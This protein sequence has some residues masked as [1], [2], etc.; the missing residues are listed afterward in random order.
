MKQ[1][2][3]GIDEGK[4][5]L[6]NKE[7]YSI[8]MAFFSYVA[9]G[10]F[11]GIAYYQVVMLLLF[12]LLFLLFRKTEYGNKK[13]RRDGLILSSLF[14][15]LLI[16]G[17]T[18]FIGF[19]NPKVS[20]IEG[21][22]QFQNIFVFIGFVFLFLCL[23]MHVLPFLVEVN[24]K[25]K[26]KMN[27][28]SIKKLFWIFLFVILLGWLPYLLSFY[29]GNLSSD[30][31]GEL[32]MIMDGFTHVSDHHPILHVLFMAIPYHVGNFIFHSKTAAVAC[33]SIVQMSMMASIFSYTAIFLYKR[34][35]EKKLIYA[36]VLFFALCPVFGYYSITM[37]KDVLFGGILLLLTI[38]MIVLFENKETLTIKKLLPFVFL[39]IITLFFRNN[40]IYMYFILA[41]V[42][43][44]IFKKEWK[45]FLLVFVLVIGFYYGV[46]GPVFKSL[47]I[48][49]SASAE[50]LAIPLQQM[51]RMAYKEGTFTEEDKKLL[52]PLISVEDL[53]K[54]YDPVIVDAIKFNKVYHGDVFDE[55]KG[56]Y[57]KLWAKLVVQNP[58]VAV[59]AYLTSTLGY[60]YPNIE[61][62]SVQKGVVDESYGVKNAAIEIPVLSKYVNDAEKRTLP[63]VSMQW[64]IGLGV[65]LLFFFAYV[66]C[67]RGTV[68]NIYPFVPVFG[69]W[70]TM[71]IAAPVYAEFRYMFALF[72]VLPLLGI[73]AVTVEK[74]KPQIKKKTKKGVR[75]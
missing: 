61:Y 24:I 14:S 75:A 9:L 56:A 32:Q 2:K 58:V 52:E 57:L 6:K 34:I 3:R 48:Q 54:L 68:K 27:Q 10:K 25:E 31:L 33:I 63:L 38:Q 67:K 47:H 66:A 59:E 23:M 44:I 1:I 74:E 64:S 13:Y 55:N 17:K 45:K 21:L 49:K 16:L 73:Y 40:A 50:Y 43:L 15:F 4:N 36:L 30:S 29:P 8:F 7:V 72:T 19:N 5:L 60:W 70:L 37:W 35:T 39:S 62:W 41:I 46:K 28:K 69:I 12:A 18:I 71:L 42:S 11:L 22:F 65:W 20:F 51:G 53:K 26:H